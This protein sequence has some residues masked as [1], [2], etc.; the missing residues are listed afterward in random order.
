[1]TINE[2]VFCVIC[3]LVVFSFLLYYWNEKELKKTTYDDI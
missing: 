1:M 2:I 3:G